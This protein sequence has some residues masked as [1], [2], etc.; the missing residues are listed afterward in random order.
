MLWYYATFSDTGGPPTLAL[1]AATSNC[2]AVTSFDDAGKATPAAGAQVRVDGRRFKANAA[3]K[4]CV[5]RHVGVVRAYA[6]G[7]VRSNAVK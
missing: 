4:V 1:K 5:G 3:G 6:V 2:Y 7:A